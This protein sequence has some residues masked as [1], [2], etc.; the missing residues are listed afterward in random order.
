MRND[1]EWNEIA[2]LPSTQIEISSIKE[3]EWYICL[4]MYNSKNDLIAK[5]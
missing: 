3:N 2:L 5:P 4:D 1:Y